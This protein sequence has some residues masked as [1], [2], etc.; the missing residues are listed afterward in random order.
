[1]KKAILL[2]AAF[3]VCLSAAAW[4]QTMGEKLLSQ[5]DREFTNGN[6]KSAGDLYKEARAASMEGGEADLADKARVRI[7]LA[8][9]AIGSYPYTR[10]DAK[11]MLA[12]N[13]PDVS[14]AERDAWL[15]NGKADFLKTDN[16]KRY[17]EDFIKNIKFRDRSLTAKDAEMVGQEGMFLREYNDIIFKPAGD[18]FAGSRSEP[19]VNPVTFEVSASLTIARDKLPARGILHIW[20]PLP[21]A[22]AAQDDVRILS[23]TPEE[24]VVTVPRTDGDLGIVYLE[25]PLENLTEDLTISVEFAFRHYEQRFF[26]DPAKVGEYD[27]ESALYKEYTRSYGNTAVTPAIK[28]LTEEITKGEKNPYLAAKMIYDHVVDNVK[29][30]VTPHATLA[31]VGT[32]ESVFVQEN[33]FGDCGAQ[34]CYFSALCRA[35]GIPVRTTGGMQLCPA[36]TST[37]FWAEFYLPN[38]GW[39]PVDTSIAQTVDYTAEPDDRKK[40]FKEYYFGSQDPYRFVMQKDIDVPL[41]PAPGEQI[42]MPMAI[43]FPVVVS[44]SFENDPTEMVLEGW[45]IEINPAA[46]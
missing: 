27:K 42:V 45:K 5:G 19:Y 40:I 44:K 30:S 39:I 10:E 13:F 15:N 1:M 20:V 33:K 7:Y 2:S 8:E 23:I 29:Y 26:V 37:H 16:E 24:Y 35:V 12:E 32:P 17:L 14:E 46:E 28:T 18:E 25:V 34:S 11:R 4:A 6:Y 36:E 38:Y 21:V 9:R 31:A 22:T 43:Q 3:A 41:T